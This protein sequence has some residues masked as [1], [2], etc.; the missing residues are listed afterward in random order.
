M[1]NMWVTARWSWLVPASLALLAGCSDGVP[2]GEACHPGDYQVAP[3]ADGGSG[4]T[5]CV[6]DGG[7]YAPYEGPDPNAIQPAVDA[8]ACGATPGAKLGFMCTGCGEDSDCAAGMVC[9]SFPNK[10]GNLCTRV[11]TSANA[12]S[13]CPAPSE[14]CGNNGHCKP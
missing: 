2:N 12:S 3:L 13:V 5:Q 8:G 4:L 10:G 6:A 14:G 7:G 11:C 9:F 1:A